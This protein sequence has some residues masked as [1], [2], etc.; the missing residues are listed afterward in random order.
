[1]LGLPSTVAVGRS[2]PK[3]AFYKNLKLTAAVKDAF[4]HDVERFEIVA[5]IKAATCGIPVGDAVAE[6]VVLRV[7]VRER[8]VPCGVVAAI[9]RGVPNKVLVA[10]CFGDEVALALVRQQLQ[11]GEWMPHDDTRLTLRGSTLDEVWDGICEQVIFADGATN[12]AGEAM[13]GCPGNG[14]VASEAQAS[15]PSAVPAT[16]PAK[17]CLTVDERIE[18]ERQIAALRREVTTLERKQARERQIAKRN[19]L[20]N[21]LKE[22]RRQLAALEE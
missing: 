20:F 5:S 10:C 2:I 8:R 11:V 17:P 22:A 9:A 15:S 1:M 6:V 7:D 21:R 3:N 19:A 12:G 13:L 4:T 16:A 14:A 18:R